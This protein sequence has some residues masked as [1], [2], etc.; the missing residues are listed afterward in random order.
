MREHPVPAPVLTD[1]SPIPE[2]SAERNYEEAIAPVLTVAMA[3]SDPVGNSTLRAMVQQTGLVK[4]VLEWASP[5]MIK[6]RHADDVPDVVFLDLS[7]G[8][9]SEFLF[10]QELARLRPAVH[11]IACSMKYETDAE[12]LLQAMRSGIRDF[13]QKPYNRI[14]VAALIDRLGS[15]CSA[16]PVKQ[17]GTGR[18]MVVLG[19][20]GGVG[21]STVAVNLAVQLALIPGKKT[22]LLD[23]SRPV[24]DVAALL[25]L[26]PRFQVRDALE[27]VKRLDATLFAGLLT[28]HKSGLRVLCGATRLDDWQSASL[29]V[30]E[31]LVEVAQEGF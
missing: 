10:A 1:S 22:L 5:G 27:N 14:E 23:F 16:Q 4:D 7:T 20:K 12:F 24:G 26:K 25:D 19:T 3:G 2:L 15:E 11:I 9:G 21:A 18:V 8:M 13:L 28:A 30:I 6:L 31:R 29:P 17:A